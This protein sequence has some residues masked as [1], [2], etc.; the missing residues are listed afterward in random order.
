MSTVWRQ[1]RERREEA[2]FPRTAASLLMMTVVTFLRRLHMRLFWLAASLVV[3]V[4]MAA[5]TPYVFQRESIW[6][7]IAWTVALV[8]SV[9]LILGLVQM[10]RLLRTAVST[11]GTSNEDPEA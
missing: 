11:S 1:Q 9:T 7:S 6:S 4:V 8:G 2:R 3:T 5:A 10:E